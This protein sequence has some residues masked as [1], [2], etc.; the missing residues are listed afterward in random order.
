MTPYLTPR[1]TE[2]MDLL[3]AE[4][5]LTR[6][7]LAQRLGMSQETLKKRLAFACAKYDVSTTLAAAVLHERRRWQRAESTAA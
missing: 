1:E 2:V 6:E 7:Q 4:P 3:V 5:D